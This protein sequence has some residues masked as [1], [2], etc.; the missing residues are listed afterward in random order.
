MSEIL[1]RRFDESDITQ[2]YVDWLNDPVVT[3]YSQQRHMQHTYETCSNYYKSFQGSANCFLAIELKSTGK[4]IGTATVYKD[5]IN[6]VADVGLMIGDRTAWGKGYGSE[7]WKVILEELM[8]DTTID[9]ITAGTL[10]ANQ[11]MLKI[12]N[13]SPLKEEAVRCRQEI[14]EGKRIDSILFAWHRE[15]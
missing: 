3:R 10:R 11:G 15:L 14:V 5:M 12:L 9:K 2:S 7:S 13:K 6:R 4:M 8:E 1:I